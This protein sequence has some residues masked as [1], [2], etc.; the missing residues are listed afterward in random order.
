MRN[1]T[2]IA[3]M[4]KKIKIV[5]P[6]VP[7]EIQGAD[8]KVSALVLE[9]AETAR[10]RTLKVSGVFEYV[11]VNPQNVLAYDLLERD[12]RGY[13]VSKIDGSTSIPGLFVAGDITQIPLK[14]VVTAAASGALAGFAAV[15]YIDELKR[16][17]RR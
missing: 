5:T 2:K 15:Q 16:A 17:R 11:G 13:I 6:Y 14:Q 7:V 8:G 4:T 1:T 12:D 10:K 9:S 3:M